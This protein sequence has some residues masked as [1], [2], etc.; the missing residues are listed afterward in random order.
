MSAPAHARARIDP[1]IRQRR[2]DVL[3]REGRR[4]LR[5]L[6]AAAAVVAV[7]AGAVV[8]TRSPLL[9]VDYVDVRGAEHTPRP[10]L[11]KVT[12]LDGSPLLIDLSTDEIAR[13]AERLPWVAEARAEKEWP[14]TV[15]LEVEERVATATLPGENGQWVLV[16][17]DGRILE[18]LPQRPADIPAVT[19]L[20]SAGVPGSAVAAAA[21]GAL[22]VAVALP[23]EVRPRVAE[24]VAVD[25][26]EVELKL[27]PSGAVRL[28]PPDLLRAKM[29]ALATMVAKVDLR[30][31]QVLDLRVP[32]A[33]VVTRR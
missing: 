22:Q 8:A 25:G 10:E 4:R 11:L 6:T 13:R 32:S 19:G 15:R 18:A 24:V 7:A 12:G 20:A 33:P 16:D 1:R 23:A 30:R 28:G 17:A 26:G 21:A 14:S 3:R 2:N 29:E 31:L 9:D 5:H 27:L